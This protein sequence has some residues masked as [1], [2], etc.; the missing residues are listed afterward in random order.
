M[1]IK[2]IVLDFDGVVVESNDIKHQAFSELFMEYPEHYDEMM[3]YHRTHNHV[4]RHD[5]FKYIIENI[6]GEEYTTKYANKMAERFSE[7]TRDKIINC[8]F[9]DKAF[10]FIQH[11]FSNEYPLYIASATPL[12]ELNIILNSRNLLPYFKRAYGAPMPKTEMF[13]DII[14]KEKIFQDELLFIG[15]SYE[16]YEVAVKAGVSFIAK[17]SDY[18]FKG[19]DVTSFENIS[20][21]ESYILKS[22]I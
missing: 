9:V 21:I 1:V 19:V 2:T 13:S 15:D 4:C 8:P 3:R 11:F 18:D 6:L 12:D 14:K 22:K 10:E 17:I 5:K 16:D 20:E 7:L